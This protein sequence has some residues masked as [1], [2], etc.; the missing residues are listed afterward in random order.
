MKQVDFCAKGDE[1]GIGSVLRMRWSTALPYDLTFEMQTVRI[2]PLVT[3]EGRAY[4]R[5]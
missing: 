1:A 4:R 3:I 5:T 2:E